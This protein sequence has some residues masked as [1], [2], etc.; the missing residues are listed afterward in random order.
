MRDPW[1][2]EPPKI[3]G[4][5]LVILAVL[6]IAPRI[7]TERGGGVS[8]TQL[9]QPAGSAVPGVFEP[10]GSAPSA[11]QVPAPPAGV[12]AGAQQATIARIVDGDTVWV[13]VREPG[14]PLPS[15]A[16]HKVR[17][18]LIDAP[19]ATQPGQ[20][21]ECGAP[22]ATQFASQQLPVGSTVHLVA[23]EQDTDQYGRFLRYLW[24]ADGTFFNELAALQGHARAVL[25]EPNDAHYARVQAAEA[26]ARAADRGIWGPPCQADHIAPPAPIPEPVAPAAPAP[27]PPAPVAPPPPAVVAP[28]P[29][30]AQDPAGGCDPN[31]AGCVPL[32]DDV[33]CASGNGNGPAYVEGPVRVIGVDVYDLD[34]NNDG[35]GCEG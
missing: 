19:E 32:A 7:G 34:G 6:L 14:G 17:L 2:E 21:P 9:V 12:P 1:R 20:G 29:P 5:L 24:S 30:P 23:D 8:E 33:D 13:E 31:Y 11:D 27:P 22:E 4:P 26:A 10:V 16:V 15:A 18:L 25:Y 3:W 35:I 28:P